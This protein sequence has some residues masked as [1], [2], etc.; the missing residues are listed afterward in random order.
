MEEI[1]IPKNSNEKVNSWL[2][3]QIP[4]NKITRKPN[5]LKN[6]TLDHK[7]KI[8]KTKNQLIAKY[9]PDEIEDTS[10]PIPQ[11]QEST[12]VV[13]K[14]KE[15]PLKD[16]LNRYKK[17][18]LLSLGFLTL[19]TAV[20]GENRNT[21]RVF[22]DTT[23][24]SDAKKIE[25]QFYKTSEKI[26]IKIANYFET[27]KA[28]ISKESSNEI[29]KLI[30]TY[31]N[32]L[33]KKNIDQFLN[34]TPK[35]NVSC[36]PRNTNSYENGNRGLAQA[37]AEETQKII[38]RIAT[39]FDF[40]KSGLTSS[41]I[42]NIKE[43]FNN[44]EFN[45]PENGVIDYHLVATEADWLEA[46]TN[47][48]KKLEIYQRMRFVNLELAALNNEKSNS[49][50]EKQEEMF[51]IA[52]YDRASIALDKSPSMR[53]RKEIVTRNLLAKVDV[54]IPTKV[55]GY[56][57]KLDTVFKSDNLIDAAE[58]IKNM[59]FVN[60]ENEYAINAAIQ[61]L[62]AEE[63]DGKK[64]IAFIVTDEELQSVSKE[65]LEKLAK[66]SLEKNTTLMFTVMIGGEIF[67]LSLDDINQAF[68]I[69]YEK[70]GQKEEIKVVANQ[71]KIFNKILQGQEKELVAGNK[72]KDYL[73]RLNKE[74][75]ETKM[76]LAIFEN[77]LKKL[78]EI[79]ISNF[80]DIS[81][82][83]EIKHLGPDYS[84]NQN[85][86]VISIKDISKN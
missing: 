21:E 77:K 48:T 25:S 11:A 79:N 84:N 44:L 13:E 23:Q 27:D 24:S 57:N 7:D 29:L 55:F 54:N 53:L 50:I 28:E 33:N 26:E 47:E 31:I 42:N 8:E 75:A 37:R 46:K 1:K 83:R 43:K 38:S 86:P 40:S 62:E 78:D 49:S 39:N 67:K 35:L 6:E 56:T 71:I 76:G 82:K 9:P 12:P 14:K 30:S 85:I 64:G 5:S 63:N 70:S 51:D 2:K 20:N 61:V 81:K 58:T 16:F 3:D 45:I 80:R 69:Q 72:N 52:G 18:L 10:A 41:Q 19:A 34:S 68:D 4:E 73:K 15:A 36:D 66:L 32:S 65:K 22:S 59:Q 17:K 60:E 74:I